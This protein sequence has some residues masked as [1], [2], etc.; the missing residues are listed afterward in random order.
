MHR[1]L[2]VLSHLRWEWVWQRPQHLISRIG[3]DCVTWFVEEPSPSDVGRPRLSLE[4][5][6]GVRRAWLDIPECPPPGFT[7]DL[8]PQYCEGLSDLLGP[9][10]GERVVWLYTPLALDIARA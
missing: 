2:I 3:R 10:S 6:G 9:S 4:N 1:E 7:E 5:D 8:M